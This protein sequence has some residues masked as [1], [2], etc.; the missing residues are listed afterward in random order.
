MKTAGLISWTLVVV[1]AL[2]ALLRE[3]RDRFPSDPRVAF[4][5]YFASRDKAAPEEQRERL[6]SF[7][8]AAPDNALPNY[9][10]AHAYFK[11]GQAE[12]AVRELVAASGK[13]R[14]QDYY[15]ELVSSA[16]EGY[17]AAGLSPLEAIVAASGQPLPHLAPL[18]ALG[19]NLGELAQRYRQA[20]DE[21]SA[22]AAV[23]LAVA[24]GHQVAEPAPRSTVIGELTGLAIERQILA[25]LNPAGPY[26]ASGRPV[27]DRL[28]ELARERTA[29]QALVRQSE[30]RLRALPEADRVAF[31]E[32]FR[33]SSEWEALRWLASQPVP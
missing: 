6:E 25:S 4:A 24:L 21:A 17:E 2:T 20:G 14:F 30:D 15:A 32:R 9:L 22:Q 7:K 18:K 16:E 10:S 8:Q 27:R 23:Q 28:D 29:R 31:F 11:S 19:Q 1:A 33:T 13:P 3:A 12:E 26:D 5:A